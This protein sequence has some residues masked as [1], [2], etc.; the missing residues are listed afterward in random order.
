MVNRVEGSGKV[1]QSENADVTFVHSRTKNYLAP[2]L[3][4]SDMYG[5]DGDEDRF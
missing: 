4:L 5:G 1:E 2:L 3:I